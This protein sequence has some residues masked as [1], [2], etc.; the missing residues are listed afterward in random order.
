MKVSENL[1]LLKF[2]QWH[3]EFLEWIGRF[4][5][6]P[7]DAHGDETRRRIITRFHL[8]SQRAMGHRWRLEKAANDI[9]KQIH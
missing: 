7:M 9:F 2:D 8:H 3:R 5:F 4:S 6:F 1:R